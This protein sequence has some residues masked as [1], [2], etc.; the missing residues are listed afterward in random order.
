MTLCLNSEAVY[1]STTLAIYM[2][3][4]SYKYKYKYKIFFGAKQKKCRRYCLWNRVKTI[5]IA[6]KQNILKAYQTAIEEKSQLMKIT[7][8]I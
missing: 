5:K 2:P 8:L 1:P 6:G 3:K 4:A 7:M